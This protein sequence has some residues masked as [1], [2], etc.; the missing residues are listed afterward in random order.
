M[1]H[2][3]EKKFGDYIQ[4]H[5][6]ND[7]TAEYALVI[8]SFGGL[9]NQVAL[10]KNAKVY[11]LLDASDT[12]EELLTEGRSKFKGSKLFPFP[13]RIVNGQYSFENKVYSFPVNFPHENNAI[14][15]I[16]LECNFSVLQKKVSEEHAVLIIQY[17]TK[18]N[19][20]GYPFKVIITIE[21]VLAENSFSAKTSIENVDDKNIP[22]GDGWH[23]YFKTGTKVDD[24]ILTLPVEC[25][26][27]VDSRMIPTGKTIDE[28]IFKKPTRIS[29]SHFDTNY[30]LA[31]GE[32]KT[33]S[34]RLK[35]PIL[36]ITIILWQEAGIGKYN[37]LQ[38]YTPSDRKSI[39]IEPMTCLTN[40]F[41][42][43]EGLIVLKPDDKSDFLFGLILE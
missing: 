14:H 38:I 7:T 15:G 11:E 24:C 19:E 36:N 1:F 5:L 4:Y 12:Y 16:M 27:E 26:Y 20:A 3:E 17:K 23:P 25:S 29:D 37:Y 18:G 40:A 13:N 33:A 39:A 8:P 6:K 28:T 9:L 35:D 10:A 32:S 2:I 34:V 22:V 31:P 30:K 42:N 21:Y 43:N 41:N